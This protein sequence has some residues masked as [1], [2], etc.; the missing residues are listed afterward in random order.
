MRQS[1]DGD[2]L[3]PPTETPAKCVLLASPESAHVDWEHAGR[4]QDFQF[5]SLASTEPGR[6]DRE[7]AV[8]DRH[9]HVLGQF[10]GASMEPGREDREHRSHRLQALT[11]QN[12]GGCERCRATHPSWHRSSHLKFSKNAPTSMRAV[13]WV[14]AVKSPLAS[15]SYDGRPGFRQVTGTSQLCYGCGRPFWPEVDHHDR[16]LTVIDDLMNIRPPAHQL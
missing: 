6:V 5:G 9:R 13:P 12:S 15:R 4:R 1:A 8:H 14:A 2:A 10:V 11:C 3:T 7:H 16:I